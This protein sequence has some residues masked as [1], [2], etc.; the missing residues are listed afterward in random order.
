MLM[1]VCKVDHNE[2]KN[3][4]YSQI[5]NL[6][7]EKQFRNVDDCIEYKVC[8]SNSYISISI[9]KGFVIIT[10]NLIY[11]VTLNLLFYVKSLT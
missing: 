9:Q 11:F 2:Y 10:N 3:W 6:N 4:I 8:N 1:F 5:S 7:Y